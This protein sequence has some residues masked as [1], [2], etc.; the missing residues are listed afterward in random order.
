MTGRA[1]GG[2]FQGPCIV[3]GRSARG[4]RISFPPGTPQ[5]ATCSIECAE[6]F[7]VAL[8]KQI[9][10]EAD[11]EVAIDA[12]IDAVGDYLGDLGKTDLAEMTEEEAREIVRRVALAFSE[13]LAKQAHE[14]VP[15]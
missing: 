7:I 13:S 10:I 6:T 5:G 3:C 11:E 12:G 1:K 9:P 15:F 2:H 14:S 8:R 4:Y